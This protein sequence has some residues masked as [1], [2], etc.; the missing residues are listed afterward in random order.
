[1]NPSTS[2]ILAIMKK[3]NTLCEDVYPR[4]GVTKNFK[5]NPRCAYFKHSSKKSLDDYSSYVNNV[6]PVY[7][8]ILH[9]D[10]PPAHPLCFC[11]LTCPWSLLQKGE[12]GATYYT[13]SMTSSKILSN[14]QVIDLESGSNK[15]P[16]TVDVDGPNKKTEWAMYEA[17][18][19][20][21]SNLK[22]PKKGKCTVQV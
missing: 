20:G 13:P 14:L 2:D 7:C 16:V 12:L 21:A 19:Y 8:D 1:V 5:Q 6:N 4:K 22:C 3:A 11:L 9:L 10:I 17:S 18:V 15:G